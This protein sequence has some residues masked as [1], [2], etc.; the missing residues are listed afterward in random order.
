VPIT[1]VV[2]ASTEGESEPTLTFDGHRVVIGRGPSCDVRLPDPSVSQRH[3]LIR[4][5]GGDYQ[6]LD[7]GSTNGTWVGGVALAPKAPR[8]LRSGDLLRVGR[9][10]IEVRIDQAAPTPDIAMATRD[11]A[12][13]L[14]ARGLGALGDDTTP[15]VL[16]VEG[17]DIGARMD[18]A[19]EGRI[20]VVGRGEK[21][22]LLL[23]D[24]DASR[25]HVQLV[26]RG[27]TVLLRDLGSK[28]GALLG[29]SKL[30]K[31]RDVPWKSQLELRIGATVMALEEPVAEALA[32]LEAAPDEAVPEGD[33]PPP[34]PK[35]SE[36]LGDVP[37]PP[38]SAR[39]AA[40][41]IADVGAAKASATTVPV[42]KRRSRVTQSDVFIGVAAL[43][44]IALSIAGLVWV[45][46][47]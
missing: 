43:V 12:L 4:A 24:P 36:K 42:R 44:I 11:L 14:V 8:T 22:D 17:P 5:Q 29:E 6:V 21:C 34:P 35:S 23:A 19:D 37:A 27:S 45:L 18:L 31:G 13:A 47:G 40:A 2:R 25:E 3:A 10:W 30:A 38:P 28:N 16:V 46:K 33:A 1:L 20:Y 41:P 9:V 39:G 26:R 15:K 32:E 7:E